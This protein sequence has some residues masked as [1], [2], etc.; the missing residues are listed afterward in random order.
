MLWTVAIIA[1]GGGGITAM[2]R[3]NF[4]I[5]PSTQDLSDAVLAR[6]P[7]APGVRPSDQVEPLI[8]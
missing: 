8:I 1:V 4:S 5:S 2:A 3:T 6:R 7:G